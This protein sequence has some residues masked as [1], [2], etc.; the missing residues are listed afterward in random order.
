MNP[1]DNFYEYIEKLQEIYAENP[2]KATKEAKASLRRLS[3]QPKEGIIGDK[4]KPIFF[5]AIY[6]IFIGLIGLINLKAYP[7]YLF[8]IVFFIAGVLIG[9]YMKGFGLIFLFSHG[10][11]GL[12]VIASSQLGNLVGSTYMSDA[13]A[14]MYYCL[15]AIVL[16]VIIATIITILYNLSDSL[17]EKRY[18]SFI[19]LALYG[20]AIVSMVVLSKYF[21]I[22]YGV[23][24]N[25]I[26]FD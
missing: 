17:R 4:E 6:F 2:E 8:G 18:F 5:M 22:H 7:G 24:A 1:N 14:K 21:L 12:G 9:L 19:P 26:I 23:E 3:S 11:T 16:L 13:P 25:S 15:I 10:M 20:I